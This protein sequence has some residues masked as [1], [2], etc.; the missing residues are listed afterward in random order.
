[1]YFYFA[2]SLIMFFHERFLLSG[3]ILWG[4]GIAI[5]ESVISTSSPIVSLITNPLTFE[6]IAGGIIAILYHRQENKK[7]YISQYSSLAIS[8]SCLA[9]M[10]IGNQFYMAAT[11]SLP[12][13]LPRVVIFGIPSSI[14]VYLLVLAETHKLRIPEWLV[15]IG[16][17][18]YSIY[19]SHVLV[20]SALGRVFFQ[21]SFSYTE[22]IAVILILIV[23]SIICGHL[24]YKFIEQPILKSFRSKSKPYI[25]AKTTS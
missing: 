20:L 4:G 2:F 3:L 23:T 15:N 17:A 18:S 25:T 5:L 24:S 11:N 22:N 10:L 13:G 21:P 8:I 16:N 7:Q 6:F 19:L 1:M 14:A 9:F 12:N